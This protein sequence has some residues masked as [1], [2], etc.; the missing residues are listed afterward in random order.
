MKRRGEKKKD[1]MIWHLFEF[2]QIPNVLQSLSKQLFGWPGFCK[3]WRTE[4]FGGLCILIAKE[5]RCL[6]QPGS[7]Y[8]KHKGRNPLVRSAENAPFLMLDS[9]SSLRD[10]VHMEMKMLS[11]T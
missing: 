11:F 6:K 3:M 8:T 9:G 5:Q 2:E 7:I 1:R 10:A 4:I